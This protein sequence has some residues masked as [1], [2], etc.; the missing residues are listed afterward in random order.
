V[1]D[2]EGEGPVIVNA[3]C[4]FYKQLEYPGERIARLYAGDP[5]R[6]TFETWCLLSRAD[7]PQTIY[8]AGGVTMIWVKSP[9]QKAAPLPERMRGI[10]S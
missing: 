10:V 8:V 4:N 9:A 5:A 7:D 2:P 3:L 6:T 1:P